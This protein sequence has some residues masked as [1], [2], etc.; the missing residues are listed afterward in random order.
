LIED[1]GPKLEKKEEEKNPLEFGDSDLEEEGEIKVTEFLNDSN[2]SNKLLKQFKQEE[3][4]NEH[5]E[6]VEKESQKSEASSS[7]NEEEK[8]EQHQY[9]IL[10]Q[11]LKAL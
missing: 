5:F 6:K 9:Q 7:Q 8:K 2:E 4:F 11:S 10:K 3:D 1:K